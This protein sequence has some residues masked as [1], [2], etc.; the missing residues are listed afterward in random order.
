MGRLRI[1]DFLTQCDARK[2]VGPM[3][4]PDG[5]VKS[6]TQL[7]LIKLIQ[8]ISVYSNQTT[9]DC[10]VRFLAVQIPSSSVPP[11]RLDPMRRSCRLKQI[12][13]GG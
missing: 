10:A 8:N 7:I 12:S 5:E 9:F 2:A 3:P 1:P 11:G 4:Q 13:C 6:L